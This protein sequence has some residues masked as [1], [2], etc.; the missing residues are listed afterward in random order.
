MA[1]TNIYGGCAMHF[2]ASSSRLRDKNVCRFWPSQFS[3]TLRSW[4]RDVCHV[5]IY[6]C[7]FFRT[8][9]VINKRPSLDISVVNERCNLSVLITGPRHKSRQSGGAEWRIHES[10]F[11][12]DNRSDN[13]CDLLSGKD[14]LRNSRRLSA[15][16]SSGFP[17]VQRAVIDEPLELKLKL[18]LK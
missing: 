1:Y 7:D 4:E 10:D 6:I 9:S 17:I 8:L 18:K 5:R 15:L 11:R 3:S 12:Q 13:S 16:F 2:C 14:E